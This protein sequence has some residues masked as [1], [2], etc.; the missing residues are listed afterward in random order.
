M[1][2]PANQPTKR[3]MPDAA[4]SGDE[5]RYAPSRSGAQVSLQAGRLYHAKLVE[6]EREA[7]TGIPRLS[8]VEA[9]DEEG[10]AEQYGS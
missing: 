3:E 2:T 5:A 10:G 7:I 6:A 4:S 8:E 9:N 1:V